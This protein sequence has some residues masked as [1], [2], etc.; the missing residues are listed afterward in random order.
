MCGADVG[1]SPQ[2]VIHSFQGTIITR[3]NNRTPHLI[4]TYRS[5][6]ALVGAK[7]ACPLSSTAPPKSLSNCD[8]LVLV[9][10]AKTVALQSSLDQAGHH[11]GRLRLLSLSSTEGLREIRTSFSCITSPL[12]GFSCHPIEQIL[13]ANH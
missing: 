4:P 5:V 7:D 13:A 6:H 12:H 1:W 8:C 3:A 9:R 2:R 11:L 10:H